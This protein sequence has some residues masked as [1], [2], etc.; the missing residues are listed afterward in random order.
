MKMVEP[1]TDVTFAIN[2]VNELG[3][4]L[5]VSSV[6]YL[7][8]DGDN[9]IVIP[10][11]STNYTTVSL[12]PQVSITIP[13]IYN[14]VP[15]I[16]SSRAR[17]LQVNVVTTDKNLVKVKEVYGID[18]LTPISFMNRSYQSYQDAELLAYETLNLE[19]WNSET[20][21]NKINALRTAFDQIGV[22]SFNVRKYNVQSPTSID[23]YSNPLFQERWS[24]KINNI[25]EFSSEY[26]LTMPEG[27]IKALKLAQVLQA[28]YVLGKG[29]TSETLEQQRLVSE[30]VGE[31]SKTWKSTKAL[32]LPLCES[33]MRALTGYIQFGGKLGH[34]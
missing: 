7:L 1:N 31:S 9:N 3:S 29:G 4:A 33:A 18:S 13:A 26:M 15:S 11:T 12:K 21:T 25:N 14:I 2:L 24:Y 20:E 27:F 23:P 8:F 17:L 28:D 19:N 34:A 32:R 10:E 22:L 5:S 16:S 30:T 6:S